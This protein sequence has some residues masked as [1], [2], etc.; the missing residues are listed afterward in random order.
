[1]TPLLWPE[2]LNGTNISKCFLLNHTVSENA[3]PEC[4]VKSGKVAKQAAGTTARITFDAQ[5][6]SQLFG[7][8]FY[9]KLTAMICNKNT[10][11]PGSLGPFRHAA[12]L[13]WGQYEHC[14]TALLGAVDRGCNR[15]KW[16]EVYLVS[17]TGNGS[18]HLHFVNANKQQV[19][20]SSLPS[21]KRVLQVATASYHGGHFHWPLKG[22]P[23]LGEPARIGAGTNQLPVGRS[24]APQAEM[25]APIQLAHGQ[26]TLIGKCLC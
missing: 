4:W 15:A 13:W 5:V 22:R 23:V 18:K 8:L 16:Q 20:S 1:M 14:R 11:G 3:A 21:I 25:F 7:L 12:F 2:T 9:W 24:L 17:C 10:L 19:S 26:C 6:E